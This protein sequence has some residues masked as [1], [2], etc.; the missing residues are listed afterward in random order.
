MA[1]PAV[2]Q[3]RWDEMAHEQVTGEITR[4]VISGEREMLATVYLKQGAIVPT[5]NHES[6]QITYVLEGALTFDINGAS[7]ILGAGDV[8]CI[9]SWV[10]HK[11]EALEDTVE[12]DVFSPIR[13]DWIDK[14]DDYFRT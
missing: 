14:T 7:I 13:Q 8:L 10:A 2:R 12:L 5:H 11:A 9:P 3:Y 4:K 1:T 6:E